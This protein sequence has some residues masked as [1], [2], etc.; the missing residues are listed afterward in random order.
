MKLVVIGLG[1]C[2]CRVADEF[3][4]LNRRA[5]DRVGH[6]I[7]PDIFAISTNPL[8]LQSLSNVK[9]DHLHRITLGSQVKVND[10]TFCELGAQVAKRDSDKVLKAIRT[11]ECDVGVDAFLLIAGTAGSTGSGAMPILAK[12]LKEYY[13]NKPVYGLAILPFDREVAERKKAIYNTALC[14][15]SS[16]EAT[17]AIILVDNQR[18]LRNNASLKGNLLQINRTIVEPFFNLLCSG[19]EKKPKHVGSRVLHPGEIKETLSGWTAIGYG[20]SPLRL[21]RPPFEI[22]WDF[23]RKN[24]ET[25]GGIQAIYEALC[26]LSIGC[27]FDS[28]RGAL[29]L[30]SAPANEISIDLMKELSNFLRTAAANASIICGDCPVEKGILDVV[31]V[32]TRLNEVDKIRQFYMESASYFREIKKSHPDDIMVYSR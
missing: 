7:I 3:A 10:D 31:V 32:L 21:I 4:L 6:K 17:D 24:N 20:K 12:C 11:T 15:K 18:Y 28:A 27:S 9:H 29:F 5:Y 30:V 2:G 25:L 14:L 26:N 8:E 19:E 13:F 22:T 23:R 1:Q 16:Y